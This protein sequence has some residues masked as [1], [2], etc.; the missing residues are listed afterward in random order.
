MSSIITRIRRMFLVWLSDRRQNRVVRKPVTTAEFHL[1]LMRVNDRLRE[2]EQKYS[3]HVVADA[4]LKSGLLSYLDLPPRHVV[5]VPRGVG[6]GADRCRYCGA[7][8]GRERSTKRFCSTK[9]RVYWHRK[10]PDR[11]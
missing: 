5:S 1:E 10:A 11:V 2:L 9:C 8:M 4:G 7:E 6:T 3:F